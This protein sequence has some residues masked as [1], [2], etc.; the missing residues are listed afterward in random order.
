MYNNGRYQYQMS[1]GVRGRWGRGLYKIE[2][3]YCKTGQA[4]EE[5]MYNTFELHGRMLLCHTLLLKHS[6]KNGGCQPAMNACGA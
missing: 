6:E 2:I 1:L 5:D 3:L 4:T